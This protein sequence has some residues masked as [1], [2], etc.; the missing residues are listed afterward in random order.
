MN[1]LSCR[2]VKNSGLVRKWLDDQLNVGRAAEV[3][4]HL[5]ACPSCFSSFMRTTAHSLF[6]YLNDGDTAQLSS[7]REHLS[8]V[9]SHGQAAKKNPKEPIPAF[10]LD[11]FIILKLFQRNQFQELDRLELVKKSEGT[12]KRGTI[13]VTLERMQANG[14]VESPHEQEGP[15]GPGISRCLYKATAVGKRVYEAWSNSRIE[16]STTKESFNPKPA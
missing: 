12:L 10:S 7:F 9:L 16:E 3:K 1:T 14:L 13:Y 5:R 15:S 8:N 2:E 11:E 4:R 6:T